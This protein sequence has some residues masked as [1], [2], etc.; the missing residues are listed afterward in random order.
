MNVPEESRDCNYC[1]NVF[2]SRFNPEQVDAP[3]TDSS[4]PPTR[5][6]VGIVLGEHVVCDALTCEDQWWPGPTFE[7][8]S[9][10]LNTV[11]G[12]VACLYPAD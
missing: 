7:A 3:P 5:S 9:P 6:M 1:Y 10:A 2:L 11:R 12:S 4:T 8:G